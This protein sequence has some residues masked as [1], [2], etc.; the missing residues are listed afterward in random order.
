MSCSNMLTGVSNTNMY[1]KSAK[2]YVIRSTI[3]QTKY[4]L[5]G[6]RS[7][8]RFRMEYFILTCCCC[9]EYG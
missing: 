7:Y 8:L 5:H 1:S 9:Y 6:Y 3:N 2:I 4:V